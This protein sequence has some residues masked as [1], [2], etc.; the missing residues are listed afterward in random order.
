MG[1]TS[2]TSP[3]ADSLHESLRTA[4]SSHRVDD[5]A[6]CATTLLESQYEDRR[7]LGLVDGATR[8]VYYS[9]LTRCVAAVPFDADDV[10]IEDAYPLGQAIDD[11]ERWMAVADTRWDWVAPA[12]R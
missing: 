12:F 8:A 1:A 2:G 7:L 5:A 4:L 3:P 10:H 9:G 6:A 11:P